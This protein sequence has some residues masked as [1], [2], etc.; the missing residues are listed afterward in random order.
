MDLYMA[1]ALI[2]SMVGL[3]MLYAC[4]VTSSRAE[5]IERAMVQRRC[6][7]A[8]YEACLQRLSARTQWADRP[9]RRHR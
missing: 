1:L 4:C 2:F 3:L 5:A 8:Q 7:R 9:P 6:R